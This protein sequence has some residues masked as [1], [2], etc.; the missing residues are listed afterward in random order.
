MAFAKRYPGGAELEISMLFVDV[1]GSTRMAEGMTPASFGQLMNRFY[2]AATD[3]LI[4]TDA[5]IDKLVG[6][7]VIGL[8]VPGMAGPEHA[9]LAVQAGQDLL[10]AV[11]REGDN[12][13]SLPVGVGIHTGTAFVG[14]AGS[15]GVVDVTALG[16]AMNTTARLASQAGAGEI[17]VS[18][19]ACAAA[20]LE[21]AGLEGRR[22]ELKG[23]SEPVSVRVLHIAP[24]VPE[25][26][27]SG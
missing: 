12:G 6:D 13:S 8:Y 16:D 19:A 17:L 3:V 10:R 15:V 7:E 9:R 4:R 5:V 27:P 23:R 11:E 25:E 21:T 22:L 24:V 18:E 20:G 14:T 1:R 26:R 2:K